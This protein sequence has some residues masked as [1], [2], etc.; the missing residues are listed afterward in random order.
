MAA[1]TAIVQ[2][3]EDQ[4]RKKTFTWPGVFSHMIVRPTV[5]AVII[6]AQVPS[7]DVCRNATMEAYDLVD[8]LCNKFRPKLCS[9]RRRNR[10]GRGCLSPPTFQS[11]GA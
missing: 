8:W 3:L 7:T 4:L 6:A 10:G 1:L 9:H 11:G 2:C 5:N